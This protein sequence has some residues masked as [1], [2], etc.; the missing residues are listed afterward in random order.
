VNYLGFLWYT[1]DLGGSLPVKVNGD[2][3]VFRARPE[4]IK[5]WK[6]GVCGAG[7]TLS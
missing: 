6:A 3:I 1:G 7:L 2:D 5:R 4:V